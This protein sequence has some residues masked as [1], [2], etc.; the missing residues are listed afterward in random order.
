[1][2]TPYALI[3]DEN[4]DKE[5][6]RH[7]QTIALALQS[8]Q[9]ADN[10]LNERKPQVLRD[11]ENDISALED[12]LRALKSKHKAYVVKWK[13]TP[14]IRDLHETLEAAQTDI[15][16]SSQT[17]GM[18]LTEKRLRYHTQNR[19]FNESN[20]P[21]GMIEL[22][23]S[24]YHIQTNQVAMG[25]WYCASFD[26][27]RRFWDWAVEKDILAKFS[28]EVNVKAD[29]AVTTTTDMNKLIL[30][31]VKSPSPPP[32]AFKPQIFRKADKDDL[33]PFYLREVGNVD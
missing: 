4:L 6:E 15:E 3:N 29:T 2:H 7:S 17:V 9:K 22:N 23:G 21:L 10:G 8:A 5:I 26:Q 33:S 14:E 19:E 13:A 28:F 27:A 24:I 20:V 1:M 30:E 16:T 12:E 32:V 31:M 25:G 18:L 11:V